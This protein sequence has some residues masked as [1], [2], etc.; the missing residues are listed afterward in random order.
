MQQV[1]TMPLLI[2]RRRFSIDE[3]Y[4]MAE[5]G[6]LTENEP[7]ELIDGEIVTMAPI[8]SRHA[9][10]VDRLGAL[11]HAK[12]S[13]NAIIRVQGPVRI[14]DYTARS[15]MYRLPWMIY[16][17]AHK[18]LFPRALRDFP[19]KNEEKPLKCGI[20]ICRLKYCFM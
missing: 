18:S 7:V 14:D 16:S 3:Y 17:K 5:A 1:I 9:G 4:R 2:E 8:G 20:K 13:G 12:L 11:F 15:R 10:S 6:I 19:Q